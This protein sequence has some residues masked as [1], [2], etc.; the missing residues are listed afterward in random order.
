MAKRGRPKKIKIE[1]IEKS[2]E[3]PYEVILT[4]AGKDHTIKTDNVAESL[5]EF[6]PLKLGGKGILTVKKDGKQFQKVFYPYTL[7]RLFANKT[8]QAIF[9]KQMERM[10]K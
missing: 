6:N 10:F 4:I 8:V 2:L 3:K 9:Q 1:S 7:K 5:V